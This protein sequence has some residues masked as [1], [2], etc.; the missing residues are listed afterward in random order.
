MNP[1]NEY[2]G[3][4]SFGIDLFDLLAV[5]G[6]LKSLLHHSLQTSILWHSDIFMVQLSQP[7]MTTG[8]KHSFDYMDLYQQSDVFAF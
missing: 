4:I 2:L 7:Y 3:L 8:K 1:T 6:T 5:Q